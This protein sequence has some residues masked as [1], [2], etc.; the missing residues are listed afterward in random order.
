MKAPTEINHCECWY[1]RYHVV[2]ICSCGEIIDHSQGTWD[3]HKFHMNRDEF[4]SYPSE[5]YRHG[6]TPETLRDRALQLK[7]ARA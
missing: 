4:E 2:H 7:G 3:I 1:H 6:D 5:L